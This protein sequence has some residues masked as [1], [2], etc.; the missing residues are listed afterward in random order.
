M[1]AEVPLVAVYAARERA[2]RGDRDDAIPL[3]RAA[4]DHL[5]REGR[6][7]GWG[8]CWHEPMATTPATGTIGIA[9]A[10]WRERL[11]SRGT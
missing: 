4:V 10:T 1:L 6:L 7:L 11:A 3:M 9:T 8:V 2:R 5:F